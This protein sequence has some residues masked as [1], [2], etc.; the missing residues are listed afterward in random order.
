MGPNKVVIA[1]AETSSFE[2]S[3]FDVLRPRILRWTLLKQE[4]F[5]LRSRS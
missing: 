5:Q 2:V 4:G 1:G 3:S